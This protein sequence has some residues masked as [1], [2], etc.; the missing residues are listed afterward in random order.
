MHLSNIICREPTHLGLC[1]ALGL[2]AGGVWPDPYMA[3]RDLVWRHPW[4]LDIISDLVSS[5]NIKGTIT[6]SDLKLVALILHE[7]TL[8]MEVPTA[9]MAVPR[10]RPDNTPTILWST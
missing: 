8:L 2:G 9:R 3:G 5:K 7:A 4:S 1:G 6:N 10:S